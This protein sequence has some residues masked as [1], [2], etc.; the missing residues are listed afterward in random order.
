M[1]DKI[2]LRLVEVLGL[3]VTIVTGSFYQILIYSQCCDRSKF[4]KYQSD[5]PVV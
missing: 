5:C 2:S 3:P 4:R 1:S